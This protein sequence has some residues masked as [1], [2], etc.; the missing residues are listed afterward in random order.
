MPEICTSGSTRGQASKPGLLY[1]P[2]YL[3]KQV[4]F[5]LTIPY[6]ARARLCPYSITTL[7]GTNN[8]TLLPN[9]GA[10]IMT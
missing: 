8:R 3:L 7:S 6:N 1:R 4:G 9:D 2:L 5:G 10:K